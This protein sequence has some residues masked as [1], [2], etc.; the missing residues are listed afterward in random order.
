[1]L[2]VKYADVMAANPEVLNSLRQLGL[3]QYEAKA[4]YALANFGIH[5]AGELA[6]R[7]ELPRPRIY[8]VLLELQNK[9]FVLIQQGRP[10]KYAALPI[11]EA[12]KTLK[13]QRQDSLEEELRKFED[14]GDKLSQKIKTQTS[15]APA[16]EENIWTI[17]GREAIYSKISSMISAAKKHVSIATDEKGWI[18]KNRVHGKEI[19][20]AAK[21]G[22]EITVIA[23]VQNSGLNAK[24]LHFSRELPSR[25]V[26]ADDQALLFLSPKEAKADEEVAL[27]LKNPNFVETFKNSFK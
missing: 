11:F 3:N 27:W 22:A 20:K 17:K 14:L 4:Y 7:A 2:V 26:L 10:V 8:D 16:L 6:L 21:R 9:G 24:H 1:V 15:A 19:E 25:V 5:T 13:K 12:V 23:P 18:S